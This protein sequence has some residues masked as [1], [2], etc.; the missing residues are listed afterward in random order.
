MPCAFAGHGR[1]CII[2]GSECRGG[3]DGPNGGITNFDNFFFAML[4]VFQCITM[5]GW[6]DVLYWVSGRRASA[7][8]LRLS[9]GSHS[10]LS[11]DER[12]HRLRAAMGLLRQSG[13]L[14][15]LLCPQSCS[16]SPE[17]VSGRFKTIGI[18]P[19]QRGLTVMSVSAAESSVKKGRRPKLEEI[20]R[21]CGRSS[22]WRRIC[23]DTWT[24]SLRRRT[25]MTWM[26]METRVRRGA[27]GERGG[28]GLKQLILRRNCFLSILDDFLWNSEP[29]IAHACKKGI[30]F[31]SLSE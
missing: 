15:F 23:A 27:A 5:E 4:T 10:S 25:W 16:G 2:N 21:N 29:E 11:A 3:W 1:Q 7:P 24:G 30:L 18:I 22:R 17:R 31:P 28:G 12:R 8:T 6:T 9:S 14:R 20:S 13:D 26:R 19:G